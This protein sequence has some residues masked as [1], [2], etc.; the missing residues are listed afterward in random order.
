[1]TFKYMKII[2]LQNIYAPAVQKMVDILQDHLPTMDPSKATGKW[3]FQ[4]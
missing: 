4:D 1:M 3:S 2:H